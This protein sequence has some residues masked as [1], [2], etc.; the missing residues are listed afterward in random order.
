MSVRVLPVSSRVKEK[1]RL[2]SE[3]TLSKIPLS[4]SIVKSSKKPVRIHYIR[5]QLIKTKLN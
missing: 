4:D 3:S 2:L 1:V 5:S